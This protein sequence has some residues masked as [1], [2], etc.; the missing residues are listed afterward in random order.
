MFAKTF[1]LLG[2]DV[3]CRAGSFGVTAHCRKV[4]RRGTTLRRQAKLKRWV[5]WGIAGNSC[6]TH[7]TTERKFI[8]ICLHDAISKGR[9]LC[10]LSVPRCALD[11]HSATVHL[12]ITEQSE[13]CATPAALGHA[14]LVHFSQYF[15]KGCQT[16]L[17]HFG[18]SS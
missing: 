4:L 10:D 5:E 18:S 6:L 13:L 12:S 16:L 17:W 9:V 8:W 3:V 11:L 7:L 2:D 1:L 15:V 14:W